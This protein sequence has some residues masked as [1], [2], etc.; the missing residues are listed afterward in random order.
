M[1]RFHRLTDILFFLGVLSFSIQTHFAWG[2]DGHI[3]INRVALQHIPSS[4]PAFTKSDLAWMEY[5][6]NEPDRWSWQDP[7]A[8]ALRASAGPEHYIDLERV[9]FLKAFPANRYEFIRALY[10]Q[11]TRLLAEDKTREADALL[12]ERLGLQPYAAT[13]VYDRLV[14]AFREYR[15]AKGNQRSTAP[16]EKNV[17]FYMGWLGH[18]VADASNPLH[19]T[20]HYNGWVGKNPNHFTTDRGTHSKFEGQFVRDN[21]SPSDF[22]K[23]VK[24][25]NEIR[26]VFSD[27]LAYLRDSFAQVV[28]LYELEKEGGFDG[29]G[30]KKSKE[31]VSDRLAAGTQKL[32]DLWY[33]AWLASEAMPAR[34]TK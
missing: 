10:A 31:F 19:T 1:R 27:Y 34:P 22:E 23:Q 17:L 6:A 21:L 20:I 3:F 28:P 33:S 5:L 7:G 13:E 25:P 18:Y 32:L 16:A 30:S 29:K 4:M 9:E 12:P 26:D 24:R 2:P 11:R 15:V 8:P 14:I